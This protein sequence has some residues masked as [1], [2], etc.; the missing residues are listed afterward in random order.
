MRKDKNEFVE[1]TQEQKDARWAKQNKTAKSFARQCG[2]DLKKIAR[3]R[4]KNEA[5]KRNRS[6]SQ[7]F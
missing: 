2:V 3:E 1:E 6:R 4:G 7:Y 5:E